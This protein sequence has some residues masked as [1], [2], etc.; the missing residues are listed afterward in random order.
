MKSVFAFYVHLFIFDN[1]SKF[2][3]LQIIW[4]NNMIKFNF[5]CCL[6]HTLP[7]TIWRKYCYFYLPNSFVC[8]MNAYMY[9]ACMWHYVFF[10]S[11]VCIAHF[12]QC[13]EI[14][15][16]YKWTKVSTLCQSNCSITKTIY[17]NIFREIELK[18]KHLVVIS[19]EKK[20]INK[21]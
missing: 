6:F 9:V 14:C 19:L 17:I 21:Y 5:W 4:W 12:S 13:G 18:W 8:Q 2:N 16:A 7:D 15:W 1:N 10:F 11:F 20:Y 3:S